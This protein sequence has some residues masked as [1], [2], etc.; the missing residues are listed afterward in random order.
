MK[1]I[2]CWTVHSWAERRKNNTHKRNSCIITL[3][4]ESQ[5]WQQFIVWAGL[6][7]LFYYVAFYQLK[8]F[9]KVFRSHS[10]IEFYNHFRLLVA[11]L[12]FYFSLTCFSLD[13][14]LNHFAWTLEV[15]KSGYSLRTTCMN[16]V[17]KTCMNV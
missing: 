14:F 7:R 1:R 10:W 6:I 12:H 15:L 13:L 3:L 5:L 4:I 9:F 2:K 11:V 17:W 16:S 8:Y